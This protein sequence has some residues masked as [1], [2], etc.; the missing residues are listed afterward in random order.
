MKKLFLLFNIFIVNV[1]S[2][3]ENY[4]DRMYV[5]Y[6]NETVTFYNNT[7]EISDWNDEN[8]KIGSFSL[9]QED[10]INFIDVKYQNN[11]NEKYLILLNEHICFIYNNRSERIFR[12]AYGGYRMGA[13]RSEFIWDGPEEVISSSYL[14]E[15]DTLYI[16]ENIGRNEVIGCPWVE[17]I[18]GNGISEYLLLKR[19]DA[20]AMFISIGFVSYDKPYLYKQNSRPKKIMLT[21]ESIFSVKIDL[22]DTPNFQTIIFPERL[23]GEIL[24][25]EILD[26]YPGTKYEDTCINAILLETSNRDYFQLINKESG[27]EIK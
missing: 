3:Q 22:D 9:R 8:K 1:V 2:T 16:A 17:G 23:K 6:Y 12:G 14:R 11:L 27:D 24:K 20:K 5:D 26:V 21:A 7:I 18:N 4:L 13:T 10:G 15:G 19:I 25:L